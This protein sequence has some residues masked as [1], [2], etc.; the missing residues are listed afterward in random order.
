MHMY[1]GKYEDGAQEA[2]C[3]FVMPFINKRKI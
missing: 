2:P 1:V 3:L